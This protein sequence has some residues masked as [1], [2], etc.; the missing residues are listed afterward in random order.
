MLTCTIR[1]GAAKRKR[2]CNRH[3]CGAPNAFACVPASKS[4]SFSATSIKQPI[5]PRIGV[6]EYEPE[7][8]G[9]G[10]IPGH[11]GYAVFL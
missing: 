2:Q 6:I 5:N 11:D 3:F 1:N 10:N 7:Q 4:N 8:F 9:F